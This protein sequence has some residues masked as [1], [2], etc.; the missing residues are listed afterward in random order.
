MTSAVVPHGVFIRFAAQFSVAGVCLIGPVVPS[1]VFPP[2]NSPS[3]GLFFI[4]EKLKPRGPQR[5]G[6]QR[7]T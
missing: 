7:T 6:I 4:R 3:W 2:K 1:A 5:K